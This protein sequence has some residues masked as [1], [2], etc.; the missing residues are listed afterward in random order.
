MSEDKE[1]V[2]SLYSNLDTKDKIKVLEKVTDDFVKKS[3]GSR[4]NILPTSMYTLGEMDQQGG[5]YYTKMWSGAKE[6]NSDR[7]MS[8]LKFN[9]SV[10]PDKIPNLLS[11]LYKF[12]EQNHREVLGSKVAV[13]DMSA[14]HPRAVVYPKTSEGVNIVATKLAKFLSEKGYRADEKS[15]PRFSLQLGEA[16]SPVFIAQGDGATKIKDPNY[17]AGF[18]APNYALRLG[19]KESLPKELIKG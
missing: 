4:V 5:Y 18:E 12:E 1:G 8:G 7:E 6:V 11:D 3:G 15:T 19:V 16:D 10:S 14:D 13:A 9:I 17:K 2:G